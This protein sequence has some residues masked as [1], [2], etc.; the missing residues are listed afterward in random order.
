[1]NRSDVPLGGDCDVVSCFELTDAEMTPLP[2][3]LDSRSRKRFFLA[4]AGDA[5]RIR[6]RFSNAIQIAAGARLLTDVFVDGEKLRVSWHKNPGATL[7]V[8]GCPTAWSEAGTEYRELVFAL[9]RRQADAAAPMAGSSTAGSI[10]VD[11]YEATPYTKERKRG[12]DKLGGLKPKAPVRSPGDNKKFFE[13][14]T[15][16]A[17]QGKVISTIPKLS[18]ASGLVT[19]YSPVRLLARETIYYEDA[20]TLELRGIID[21]ESHPHLVPF[22]PPPPSPEHVSSAVKRERSKKPV[23]DTQECTI[24]DLCDDEEVVITIYKRPRPSLDL[25]SGD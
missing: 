10:Q 4:K 20:E 2:S 18:P 12:V 5:F 23:S 19:S 14:P 9:N 6:V 8:R 1:M 25:A 22:L 21:R 13:N 15:L 17:T 7:D 11:V 16:A 3:V 24:I